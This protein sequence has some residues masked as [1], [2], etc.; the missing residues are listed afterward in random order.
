MSN[1][2]RRAQKRELETKAESDYRRYTR[3]LRDLS[4]NEEPQKVGTIIKE[5]L[6][7][8]AKLYPIIKKKLSGSAA[9]AQHLRHILHLSER[10]A[11]RI[12]TTKNTSLK[13]V[14]A[15]LTRQHGDSFARYIAEEFALKCLRT[16][17]TFEFFYGAIRME[18][19][20]V[21]ERRKRVKIQAV[22]TKSVTATEKNIATDVEQDSTPKEVEAICKKIETLTDD[23]PEG[24]Q[25]FD[26]ICDPESFTKT[27]ENIFHTSFLVKE[28]KVG[29]R[30]GR[31]NKPVLVYDKDRSNTQDREKIPNQSI[32]SFSMADFRSWTGRDPRQ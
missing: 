28:G 7:E 24:V 21:K 3:E 13:N 11:R 26:T 30:K 23:N 12:G 1:E 9:D 14:I 4:R 16:S 2:D 17:P 15:Q 22:E 8:S 25:F 32:L 31:N 19:L 27:V 5:Q 10:T 29:V 20:E 6:G 18:G